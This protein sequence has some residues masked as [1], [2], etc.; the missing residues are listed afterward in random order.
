MFAT[1]FETSETP[2]YVA[3]TQIHNVGAPNQPWNW[4]GPDIGQVS[5]DPAA[6][7]AGSQ[8]LATLRTSAADSQYLYTRG[9]NAFDP[10]TGFRAQ[11]HFAVK[12]TGWNNSNDSFLEFWTQGDLL[13]GAAADANRE[14]RSA[15]IAL[16]GTGNL[17]AYPGG[18]TLT[19][20]TGLTVTDWNRVTL[21]V[22]LGAGHYTVFLNDM[23]V[24]TDIAFQGAGPSVGTLE[25]IQF[26][27][28]NDGQS[29]GGFYLDNFSLA[30]Q[31]IPEPTTAALFLL[32]LTI[33]FT[34]RYRRLSGLQDRLVAE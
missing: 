9:S 25:Q 33:L 12:A 8:G 27:H 13:D 1:G 28:F 21:E 31:V 14:N 24:G 6:V 3:G 5:A 22:N 29:S 20:A 26:K 2:A 4:T 30:R 11:V 7:F 19:L 15:W 23:E 10:L 32:T 34:I 17:I 18:D 16:T